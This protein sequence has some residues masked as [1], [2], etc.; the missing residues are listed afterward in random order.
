MEY[1][2]L[3][4]IPFETIEKVVRNCERIKKRKKER[5]NS[6][7]QVCVHYFSKVPN[8]EE[9]LKFIKSIR[10]FVNKDRY[11]VRVLGRGSRK[12]HGNAYSIPLKHSETFSIYIDQIIMDRNNPNYLSNKFYKVRQLIEEL[13]NAMYGGN[14]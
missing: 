6:Q 8:N 2:K 13:N 1:P 9:G 12:I 7:G 11:K 4:T 14:N 3:E 5:K 10:K